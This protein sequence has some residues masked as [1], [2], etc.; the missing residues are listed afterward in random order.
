M[1]SKIT[2]AAVAGCVALAACSGNNSDNAMNAD[3]NMTDLNAGMTD[4]NTT[5][6]RH[7]ASGRRPLRSGRLFYPLADLHADERSRGMPCE[8]RI[9]QA[10]SRYVPAIAREIEVAA[11]RARPHQLAHADV[12]MA[13]IAESHVD[14]ANFDRP[15]EDAKAHLVI[16]R[17]S[18]NTDCVRV[19]PI[20]S[21]ICDGLPAA[22]TPLVVVP[23]SVLRSGRNDGERDCSGGGT[24]DDCTFHSKTPTSDAQKARVV[25]MFRG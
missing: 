8:R 17:R 16:S 11:A 22:V 20:D 3:E 14:I 2:L 18:G 21:R 23:V 19:T 24:Q 13:A 4:M 9:L 5:R 10:N 6:K 25:R 15:I 12:L 1:K 7:C